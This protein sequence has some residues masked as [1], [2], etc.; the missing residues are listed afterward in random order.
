[1]KIALSCESTCDLPKEYLEK[2]ARLKREAEQ[3][4]EINDLKQQVNGLSEDLGDIKTMLTRVLN[5][6]SKED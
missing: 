5:K 4:K 6:K 2:T 3:A 1:M